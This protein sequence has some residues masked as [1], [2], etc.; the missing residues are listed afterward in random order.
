MTYLKF[1]RRYHANGSCTIICTHCFATLGTVDGFIAAGELEGRHTCGIPRSPE[2]SDVALRSF[3]DFRKPETSLLARASHFFLHFSR[4]RPAIAFLAVALA[5]YGL[6]TFIE[7]LL[8]HHVSPWF[9]DILFGDFTGCACLALLF[10]MP[11]TAAILY[12]ALSACEAL[13]Y[14]TGVLSAA[15]LIWM[16]DIIPTFVVMACMIQPHSK[17]STVGSSR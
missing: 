17:Q 5:L 6:P 4:R 2:F 16:V 10:R 12:V 15:S 9:A 8:L 13:L 3:A 11:S 14:S 7:S 1:Y